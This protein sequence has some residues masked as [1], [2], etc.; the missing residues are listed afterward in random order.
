MLQFK[1]EVCPVCGKEY[2]PAPCHLYKI[3]NAKHTYK[4]RVCSYGCVLRYEK[5]KN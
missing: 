3:P 4:I 5:S 2:I 1:K